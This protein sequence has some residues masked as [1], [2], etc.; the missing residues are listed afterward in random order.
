MNRMSSYLCAHIRWQNSISKVSD[1]HKPLSTTFR[2][3]SSSAPIPWWSSMISQSATSALW[4][5]SLT[6]VL[7]PAPVWVHPGVLA[8]PP[9]RGLVFASVLPTVKCKRLLVSHHFDF[10]SHLITLPWLWNK[11]PFAFYKMNYFHAYLRTPT[12]FD[13]WHD[14]ELQE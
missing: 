7:P 6:S 11:L 12:T 4:S 10:F 1:K 3:I 14:S 9:Q 13:I 2:S 8:C 5:S